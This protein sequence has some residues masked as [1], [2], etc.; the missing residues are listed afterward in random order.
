MISGYGPPCKLPTTV[1]LYEQPSRPSIFRPSVLL[2]DLRVNYL[3]YSV[4][5]VGRPSHLPPF[6]AVDGP[7]CKL[8]TAVYPAKSAL[9]AKCLPP[10]AT[11]KARDMQKD[12][13]GK[14]LG[15]E[16]ILEFFYKHSSPNVLIILTSNFEIPITFSF[17]VFFVNMYLKIY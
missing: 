8:P 2:T 15:M 14:G 9:F 6:L 12:K 13:T 3:Q 16:F 11:V 7:P 4:G 5:Q 1:N 10:D 17:G